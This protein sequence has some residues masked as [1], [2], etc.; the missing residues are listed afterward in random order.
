MHLGNQS[1]ELNVLP[2]VEMI[3]VLLQILEDVAV[4]EEGLAVLAVSEGKVREGH[5]LLGQVGPE[6]GV[7][8]GVDGEA[9]AVAADLLGVDPGAAHAR[10][11]LEHAQP[12]LVCGEVA[13]GAKTR[14]PRT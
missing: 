9:A 12:Q 3:T 7:H 2:E 10:R 11:L 5:D 1:V 13:R 6:V 4:V 8:A 14:G